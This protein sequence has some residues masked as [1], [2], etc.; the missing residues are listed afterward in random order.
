MT[1]RIK[2]FLVCS[3]CGRAV[4]PDGYC[5]TCGDDPDSYGVCVIDDCDGHD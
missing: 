3:R 4:D 2:H 5:E 1:K